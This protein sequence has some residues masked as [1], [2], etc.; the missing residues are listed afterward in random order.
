MN[1]ALSSSRILTGVK[2]QNIERRSSTEWQIPNYWMIKANAN[3]Q[4]THNTLVLFS[5]YKIWNAIC[6]IL[7]YS[8]QVNLKRNRSHLKFQLLHSFA[9][10][11]GKNS[12][13]F[14][15][16][17]ILFYIFVQHFHNYFMSKAWIHYSL[18]YGHVLQQFCIFSD[19]ERV[20][21]G[22]ARRYIDASAPRNIAATNIWISIT[23]ECIYHCFQLKMI[24][25]IRLIGK[26]LL[27]QSQ[28]DCELQE[29][30]IKMSSSIWISKAFPELPHS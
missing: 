13:V 24:N 28:A 23:S 11:S 3:N 7:I 29:H 14:P 17:E 1:A 4:K 27:R 5:D 20:S 15:L 10:I 8:L 25:F 30:F 21:G 18:K 22:A 2:A 9:L 16:F 19:P 12:M 6:S 26:D